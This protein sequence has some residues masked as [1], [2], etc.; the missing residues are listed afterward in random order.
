MLNWM[1]KYYDTLCQL[2]TNVHVNDQTGN[3]ISNN[4][5][6]QQYIKHVTSVRNTH[7]KVII[8]GNGGSAGIA[9]HMAIDYSKNG[10]IPALTFSDAGAMT[11]LSNDYGYEHVYAKQ[12][13]YYGRPGDVLIAI[14]SSG[15]SKNIL[16]AVKAAR[17]LNCPVITFSGFEAKNPLSLAGDVN[18]FINSKEYGFVEVAHMALGHALLDYIM[19]QEQLRPSHQ[20]QLA[21][22]E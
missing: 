8:V 4:D 7:G 22:A 9:S 20:P 10:K 6:Y 17:K 13:E 1:K 18:F 3:T 11:C 19:E 16:E 12:I 15:K 21:I 2:Q 5:G 14:S